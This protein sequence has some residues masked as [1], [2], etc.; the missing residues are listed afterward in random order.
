MSAPEVSIVVPAHNEAESLEILAAEIR[1]ALD[2][3]GT[4]YELIVVDDGS[5]DA[6]PAVLR[7]LA[8]A[9]GRVRVVAQRRRAGQSAALAAGFRRARGAIV[10]TLDADLQ[11]D[12]ADIPRLLAELPGFGLVCGVRTGRRDGGLRRLSSRLANAVRNRV[13]GERI[14]DVGC[15]LK[16]CRADVLRRV[17]AFDGM[18]RFLPTLMRLEGARVKEV[19]VSHRPRLYGT[20]KYGVGNRL[21]RALADLAAVRWMQRRSLDRGLSEE[22]ADWT[23][24]PYGSPSASAARPSSSAASSSSGSPPSAARRA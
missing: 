12:P 4:S 23:T 17:P 22:I 6:T 21:W 1:G 3:G 8:A 19:P 11:N 16:A 10:V 14:A 20:T 24:T 7:R 5:T 9:D 13:T 18:H 15:S 2:G